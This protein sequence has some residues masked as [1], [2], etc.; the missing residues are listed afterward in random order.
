MEGDAKRPY[1]KLLDMIPLTEME[2]RRWIAFLILRGLRTP[3]AILFQLNGLGRNIA[4]ERMNYS[5]EINTLRA[6]YETMFTTAESSRTST[7]CSRAASG[8]FGLRPPVSTSFAA[9]N[10]S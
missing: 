7:D 8:I 9:T 3:R 6:A 10:Q 2:R 5:T 4:R 1:S